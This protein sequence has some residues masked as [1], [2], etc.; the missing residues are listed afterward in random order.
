VSHVLKKARVLLS[1]MYAYMNEYRAELVLWALSSSLPFILL[2]LW[3]AAAEKGDFGYTPA[4]MARYFLVVFLVRQLTVVWVVWEFEQ[5]V[6]SGRLSHQL[7]LPIDPAW[8]HLAG[9]V[10]E[11]GARLPFSAIIVIGFFVLMP[12]ARFIPDA[13]WVL[14]ALVATVAAFVLRFLIQITFAM[15]AFWT[16]RASAI[17]SV[18]NLFY[19]FLSGL[20]A[21][22]DLFPAQVRAAAELT[23]FPWLVYWPAHLAIG[24]AELEARPLV[25]MALW[26]LFFFG[27]YRLLWRRGLR[28]YS[29][30]GA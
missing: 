24:R 30:M 13:R 27:L 14:A 28:R 12:S 9:H 8:R 11:R 3:S 1:V 2:G 17:Q 6:V 5:D 4:E 20:I 29:A 23:P 16:E 21:P 10:S 22:L 25:I 7:L 26:A 19:V 18:W 15:L